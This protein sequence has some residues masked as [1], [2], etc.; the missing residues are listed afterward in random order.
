M[1]SVRDILAWID[2]YA[3]FRYAESWDH[4]GLQVGDPQASVRRILVALD[5]NSATLGEAEERECQC[6]VT[7]HPLV[8]HSVN[9]V[10]ADQ[11]PGNLIIRA[12]LKGIHVIAAHTNL[13]VAKGGTNDRLGRMLS[14]QDL[15]ALEIDPSKETEDRY[16]GMGLVGSFP[17]MMSLREVVGKTQV[18]LGGIRVRAVGDAEWPIQ[19]VALC[20]GSGGSL[21]ERA[22]SADS[23]C[24][25][26][27]DIKYHDAQRAIEAG[28]AL[29][30]IGHFA[31]E[32]IVVQP[33]AAFLRAQAV[34]QQE[35]LEVL[36]TSVESDPFWHPPLNR[37]D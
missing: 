33:L 20:T 26:T 31:S 1:P 13:D 27:G 19:R 8:F 12:V 16:L 14:L 17:Q 10:R 25:I 18:V 32:R 21:L 3:P 29:I 35:S 6:L 22:I 23:D 5:P 2:L 24:F 11:F 15:Q 4:C 36:E 9:A 37:H 30:D 28:M 7:H 34:A